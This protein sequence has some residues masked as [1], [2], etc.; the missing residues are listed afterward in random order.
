MQY[1]SITQRNAELPTLFCTID[2]IT[3]TRDKHNRTIRALPIESHTAKDAVIRNNEDASFQED[4]DVMR[5]TTNHIIQQS[6][7]MICIQ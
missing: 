6:S 4:N 1:C 2:M 7:E 3:P 5:P